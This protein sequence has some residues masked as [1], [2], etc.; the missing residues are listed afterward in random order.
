M[1]VIEGKGRAKHCLSNL[2]GLAAK[3]FKDEVRTKSRNSYLNACLLLEKPRGID[4]T[5][6]DTVQISVTKSYHIIPN[7]VTLPK[8]AKGDS[9]T[10]NLSNHVENVS[11]ALSLHF[12]GDAALY[13]DKTNKV[14][15]LLGK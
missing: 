13:I 2:L 9:H 5:C 10:I 8:D 14:C 12:C 1:G 15:K 4:S 11:G 3:T 7:S 6:Y